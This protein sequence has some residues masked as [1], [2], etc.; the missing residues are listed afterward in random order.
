MSGLDFGPYLDGQGPALGTQITENQL[1]ARM[2]LLVSLTKSVRT[3]ST[4]GGL[5]NAGRVARTLGLNIVVGAFLSRDAQQN[6]REVAN[7]VAAAAAGNTGDVVIAGSE[8]LER[9]DLPEADLITA[10][11]QV[12]RALPA[13]IQLG[14]AD[15][16]YQLLDH[17][18]V[19]DEADVVFANIYPYFDGV[20]LDQAMR[21]L[22]FIF[23]RLQAAVAPKPIILSETGWPTAGPQRG[24]ALPSV[25]NAASYFRSFTTW[26]RAR[27]VEYFYF[28][29]FDEAWKTAEGAQGPHW[30]IHDSSGNLKS[31]MSEAFAGAAVAD[32]WTRP[33]PGGAGAAEL[34]FTAVA[35]LGSLDNL[36]GQVSGVDPAPYK[37]VVYVLVDGLWRRKP[38]TYPA[39]GG[40]WAADITTAPMDEAAT[41]IAAYLLPVGYRVVAAASS[42]AVPPEVVANAVASRNV[43]R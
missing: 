25:S 41:Q 4:T 17:P 37:V 1:T 42:A 40:D 21:H 43:S 15:T 16:A 26:A 33:I 6:D 39:I 10:L 19:M 29:A 28:E 23:T 34:R 38:T 13:S 9:A 30:G 8:V 22:D 20:P 7:L 35:P 2:Q 5:E 32:S 12:R 24:G 11:Q 18:A 31:G 14:Y 3:Y 27:N 36:R